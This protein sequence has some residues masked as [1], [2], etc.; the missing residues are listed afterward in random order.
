ME[1][2]IRQQNFQK[3]KKTPEQMKQNREKHKK[4]FQHI[5]DHS[6]CLNVGLKKW[7]HITNDIGNEVVF[8]QCALES[9]AIYLCEIWS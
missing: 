3:K 9:I 1:M 6:L 7:S 5:V 4:E 2:W 8:N